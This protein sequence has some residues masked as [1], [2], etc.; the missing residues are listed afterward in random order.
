MTDVFVCGLATDFCVT[1]TALDAAAAG[2]KTELIDDAS[3]AIDTNG[4]L[5][6]A[7]TA[8]SKAGVLRTTAAVVTKALS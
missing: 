8:L 6:A 4:S 3:R 1:W 2:F 5:A 7:Y